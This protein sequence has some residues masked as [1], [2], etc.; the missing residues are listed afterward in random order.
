MSARR[1]L[2]P[3]IVVSFALGCNDMLDLVSP[4]LEESEP[5][6]GSEPVGEWQ[7]EGQGLSTGRA[8]HTATLLANGD[9]ALWGGCSASDEPALDILSPAADGH[10]QRRPDGVAAPC[11][12]AHAATLDVAGNLVIAGGF[13]DHGKSSGA[14]T[15]AERYDPFE[16]EAVHGQITPAAGFWTATALGDG[17]TLFAGGSLELA[18]PSPLGSSMA[19]LWSSL[20][21][22]GAPEPFPGVV[23]SICADGDADPDAG[24]ARPRT[25][26]TA[27][28]L[29]DGS[30]L[31]AGG[32][33]G[34]DTLAT[35]ERFFPDEKR[36][37]AAGVMST[38]RWLHAAVRLGDGR[39]LVCGGQDSHGTVASAEIF[40]PAAEPA[41]R[42]VAPMSVG[43]FGHTAT[44]LGD[45]RVLVAGGSDDLGAELYDP[46][47]DTWAPTAKMAA[48]RYFHTATRVASGEVLVAGGQDNLV[49]GFSSPHDSTERYVP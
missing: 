44:L 47:R 22:A 10:W 38:P 20:D 45:G 37:E 29:A 35:A 25:L 42:D 14:S 41:F 30:V 15:A 21:D 32:Q 39:V 11:P 18:L 7:S 5:V 46:V 3:A 13:L 26:H 17:R 43:R 19:F 1:A 12:F 34:S 6:S 49:P 31:L 48:K 33:N 9:V 16:K 28:L 24:C 8:L 2:A 36:F 40:E 23:D 4:T 27:T